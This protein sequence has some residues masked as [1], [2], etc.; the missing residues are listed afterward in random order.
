MKD[1]KW[2]ERFVFCKI[3]LCY[4]MATMIFFHLYQGQASCQS[5]K[6]EERIRKLKENPSLSEDDEE[7]DEEDEEEPENKIDEANENN[8]DTKQ[9][10][11]GY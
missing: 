5:L 3:E 8:D 1:W 4:M 11:V 2:I 6:T 10:N 7:E 9:D